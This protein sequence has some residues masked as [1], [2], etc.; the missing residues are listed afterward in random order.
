VELD[1]DSIA[2]GAG[3]PEAGKSADGTP[4][5]PLQP[6]RKPRSSVKTSRRKG[7]FLRMA[8]TSFQGGNAIS[9]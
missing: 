3:L 9:L 7:I 4:E 1:A 6:A 8:V 2:D 5:L